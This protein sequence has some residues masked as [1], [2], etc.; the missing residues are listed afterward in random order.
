MKEIHGQRNPQAAKS[1]STFAPRQTFPIL[2]P[3]KMARV[4]NDFVTMRSPL[5]RFRKL[6]LTNARASLETPTDVVK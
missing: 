6:N 2:K 5:A 4:T 3:D 1:P